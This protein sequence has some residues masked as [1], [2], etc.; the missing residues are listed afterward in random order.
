ME[1]AETQSRPR[2]SQCHGQT[3]VLLSFLCQHSSPGALTPQQR[4]NPKPKQSIPS[5]REYAC[6]RAR[7]QSNGL[8]FPEQGEKIPNAENGPTP[9]PGPSALSVH[10]IRVTKLTETRFVWAHWPSWRQP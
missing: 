10:S 9:G 6:L 7:P 4:S 2:R 3:Q 5:P 1:Q 8:S